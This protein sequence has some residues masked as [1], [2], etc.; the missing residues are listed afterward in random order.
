[1]QRNTN[2]HESKK[3]F[4]NLLAQYKIDPLYTN[5]LEDFLLQLAGVKEQ[6]NN[7]P[8]L[9]FED[10]YC[11]FYLAM[12]QT[13]VTKVLELND[14][15]P[16]LNMTDV[17]ADNAIPVIQ[18]NATALGA[19]ILPLLAAYLKNNPL[20]VERYQHFSLG[21]KD[22]SIAFCQQTEL[23]NFLTDD[24]FHYQVIAESIERGNLTN[25]HLTPFFSEQGLITLILT[26]LNTANTTRLSDDIKVTTQEDL[27]NDHEMKLYIKNPEDAESIKQ[28]ANDIYPAA[29]IC[30]P[31]DDKENSTTVLLKY[32]IFLH[33]GLISDCKDSA[34]HQTIAHAKRRIINELTEASVEDEKYQSFFRAANNLLHELKLNGIN[35]PHLIKTLAT[36]L[37]VS[38]KLI[39]VC[40]SLTYL[41][42]REGEKQKTFAPR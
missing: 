41:I 20:D 3:N 16:S 28:F 22:S 14:S 17:T 19:I 6:L 24:H 23:D 9:Y 8:P 32:G 12:S 18:I 21:S 36:D 7:T 2:R 25:I 31:S 11:Y 37:Q 27:D 1:M 4:D 42:N 38:G 30:Q 26:Y 40:E 35:N 13:A 29:A 15:F 34:A 5:V 10:N 39:K 33:P